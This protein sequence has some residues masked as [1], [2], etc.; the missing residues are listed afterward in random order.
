MANE[1]VSMSTG[2]KRP[3][4]CPPL[5]A[6]F[7]FPESP[8][9]QLCALA[10]DNS[11]DGNTSA[12]DMDRNKLPE[13]IKQHFRDCLTELEYPFDDAKW[14]YWTGVVHPGH[15]SNHVGWAKG[16]P[17]THQWDGITLV[18]YIQ[19]PD[20]GG[21]TVIMEDDH[22]NI[23]HRFPPE[24]RM[25]AAMD[26]WSQHGVEEVFGETSRMTILATGYR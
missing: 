24:L 2:S 6:Q 22:V 23:L 25:T 15:K 19:V 26:G 20:S 1:I 3:A 8:V 14:R 16:F 21:D 13:S 18:H 5:V 17:H 4:E 11:V 10:L 7:E 9:E 12:R